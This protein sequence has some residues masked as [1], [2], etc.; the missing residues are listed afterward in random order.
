MISYPLKELIMFN[1]FLEFFSKDMKI[2]STGDSCKDFVD[3]FLSRG[4]ITLSF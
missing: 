1:K 2:V 3:N 4:K